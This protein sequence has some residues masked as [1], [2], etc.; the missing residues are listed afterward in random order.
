MNNLRKFAFQAPTVILSGG[1]EGP[2]KSGLEF[3]KYGTT[4]TVIVKVVMA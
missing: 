1:A 4:G 2:D 3:R